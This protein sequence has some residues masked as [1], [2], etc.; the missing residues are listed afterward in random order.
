M[1][2]IMR[3]SPTHRSRLAIRMSWFTLS[4]NASRSMSTTMVRPSATY[5]RAWA[6]ASCAPRPGRNP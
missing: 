1:I 5:C 4:K 6:S 3:L 2:F